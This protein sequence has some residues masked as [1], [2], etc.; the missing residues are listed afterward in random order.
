MGSKLTQAQTAAM[1]YIDSYA[2]S[3]PMPGWNASIHLVEGG[4]EICDGP[5]IQALF[6]QGY[7]IAVPG[8]PPFSEEFDED[9]GSIT[10][11]HVWRITDAGRLAL[12]EQDH[13]A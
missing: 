10:H 4:E 6:D 2:V 7:V 8:E 12:K 1:R 5:E 3:G 11:D 13:G 9:A